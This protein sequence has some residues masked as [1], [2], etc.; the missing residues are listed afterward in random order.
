MSEIYNNVEAVSESDVSTKPPIYHNGSV[1]AVIANFE[2]IA[3]HK[4]DETERKKITCV[5]R[6]K[7]NNERNEDADEGVK[8][9]ADV[10]WEKKSCMLTSK[11][12]YT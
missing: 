7:I 10:E 8:E 5:V 9:K 6:P 1:A 11:N 2:E 4:E 12:I 3:K